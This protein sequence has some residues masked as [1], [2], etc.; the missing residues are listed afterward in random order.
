MITVGFATGFL[1]LGRTQ[2]VGYAILYYSSSL[3]H[4][5]EEK[6]KLPEATCSGHGYALSCCKNCN[7]STSNMEE[8][9]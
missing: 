7:A 2:A 9:E 6:C 1:D 3:V 4:E 5:L 8:A